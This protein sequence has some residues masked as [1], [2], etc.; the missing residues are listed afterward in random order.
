MQENFEQEKMDIKSSGVDQW[1]FPSGN[2]SDDGNGEK[3]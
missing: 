1:G 2:D 3:E